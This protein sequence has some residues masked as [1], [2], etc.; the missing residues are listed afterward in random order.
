MNIAICDDEKVIAEGIRKHVEFYF[1]SRNIP[2][3]IT[4]FTDGKEAAESSEIFDIA[5]LDVEMGIKTGSTSAELCV[6]VTKI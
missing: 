3:S 1:K 6:K 4:M 5:F 2:C